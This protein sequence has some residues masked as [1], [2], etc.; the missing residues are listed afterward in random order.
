MRKQVIPEPTLL[1]CQFGALKGMMQHNIKS[2][3]PPHPINEG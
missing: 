2:S 3:D 1:G